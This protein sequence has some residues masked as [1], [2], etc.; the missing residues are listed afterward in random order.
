MVGTRGLVRVLFGEEEVVKLGLTRRAPQFSVVEF[1]SEF[2]TCLYPDKVTDAHILSAATAYFPF[3]L[4]L[5][6]QVVTPD[7]EG[8][9]VFPSGFLFH[10]FLQP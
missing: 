7:E 6:V 3:H 1:H 2:E 9:I 8:V 4:M 5:Q 10:Q